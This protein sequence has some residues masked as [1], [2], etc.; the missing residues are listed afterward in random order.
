MVFNANVSQTSINI[1]TI[2]AYL[3]QEC[4]HRN[5]NISYVSFAMNTCQTHSNIA[6]INR[7]M[8]LLKMHAKTHEIWPTDGCNYYECMPKYMRNGT[9]DRCTII[10][11]H[12]CIV[13]GTCVGPPVYCK[14]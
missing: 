11:Q 2:D 6:T 4:V 10:L 3:Q 14:V 7:R 5:R 1:G 8:K 13:M 9:I 12:S